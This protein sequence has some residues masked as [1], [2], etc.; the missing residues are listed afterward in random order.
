VITRNEFEWGW[1]DGE[2]IQPRSLVAGLLDVSN[3]SAGKSR[4]FPKLAPELIVHHAQKLPKLVQSRET[5]YPG[6]W[7]APGY[8]NIQG[9]E[10][11]RIS[12]LI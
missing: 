4:W 9:P 6:C 2:E 8:W 11:G 7:D 3:T 10:D 5:Y 1:Q 12:G